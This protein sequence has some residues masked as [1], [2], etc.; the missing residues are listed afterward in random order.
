MTG[1][2]RALRV[3]VGLPAA[4]LLATA[5]SLVHGRAGFWL[6]VPLVVLAAVVAA[7]AVTGVPP[8][9]GRKYDE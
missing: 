2:R 6:S 9:P 4:V 3:L 8:F 5:A 7:T 1:D